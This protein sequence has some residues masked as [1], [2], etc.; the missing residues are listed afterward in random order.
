MNN[1]INYC[2]VCN[3][4]LVIGINWTESKKARHN[5]LCRTCD[6]K[7]S[8]SWKHANPNKIKS[9]SKNYYE[10]NKSSIKVKANARYN[11]LKGKKV[12]GDYRG[13]EKFKVSHRLHNRKSQAKRE[14]DLGY[15]ELFD[16]PFPKDIPV[17]GHHISDG[18][19]VYIPRSLHEKHLH[20]KYKQ[21][22]RDELKPIIESLY[23]FSYIIS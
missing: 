23:N 20:G 15:D 10:N 9:D 3:I 17:V 4:E 8:N 19:V 2:R 22:H 7:K 14:R 1:P 11:S 18:F 12:I 13:T 6:N 21:L 5:Y 16:N